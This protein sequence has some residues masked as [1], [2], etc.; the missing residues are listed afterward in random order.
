MGEVPAKINV[1][2]FCGKNHYKTQYVVK[3]KDLR[4]KVP[5]KNT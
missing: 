1:D 5:A 3:I 2:N 4:K